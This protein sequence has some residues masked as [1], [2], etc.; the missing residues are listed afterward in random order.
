MIPKKQLE[1]EIEEVRNKIERTWGYTSK[2][3]SQKKYI[4]LSATLTRTNEIIKLIEERI[5]FCKSQLKGDFEK[6]IISRKEFEEN[7]IWTWRIS[8]F[9]E[10][11]TEIKGD[12]K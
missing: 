1:K 2:N 11:L 4:Q 3:R 7:K 8:G 5:K 10:L 6:N 12:G 9:E